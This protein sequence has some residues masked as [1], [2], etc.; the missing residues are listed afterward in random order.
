MRNIMTGNQAA[1]LGAFQSGVAFVTGYPGTPCTEVVS[2]LAKFEGVHWEWA[3][4]E[5]VALEAAIGA[6]LAGVRTLVVM[7]TLG[8]N[9]AADAF[10]QLAGTPMNGGLV[11]VVADDV[12]R[13]VGD[14]YQD[15]R[16][17]SIMSQVPL[18]EPSDSQ[19]A[20]EF[21][22]M[23]F[24]ISET[25]E[26][27]VILRLNSITSKS[28]SVVKL[29]QDVGQRATRRLAHQKS[30]QKTVGNVV[31]FGFPNYDSPMLKEYWHDFKKNWTALQDACNEI[32]I[33]QVE[34]GDREI[35]IIASGVS[36]HYAKEAVPHASF[37]KLGLVFPLPQRLI[38]DFVGSHRTVY[39]IEDGHP[40]IER[41]IRGMG[42][43]VQGENVFPRFPHMLYFTPEIIE[44]KIL[45]IQREKKSSEV[46]FRLPVNCP[47]CPH[48]VVNRILKKNNIKAV[49][50]IGCG[51]LGAFPHVGAMDVVKCMGSSF[52][53]AHGY[54]R[55]RKDG[56]K[57]V[58][59]MGDGEFWHTGM[60]GLINAVYHKGEGV[61]IIE[62][63]FTVAMTGGQRNISS[64]LKQDSIQNRISI[65]AICKTI[66][67]LDVYVVDS[68]DEDRLEG[69]L[70][71][72]MD[73]EGISVIIARHPCLIFASPTNT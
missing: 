17:Y 63:N 27:P 60:N 36:Y 42:L 20:K 39:V 28:K 31:R 14:D 21:M 11:L 66:G 8:L 2:E 51:G 70:L 47:G 43:T 54:N 33:N 23:A 5:K 12:G 73:K 34:M 15:C 25:Y 46:P 65:E 26:V 40:I 3:V 1:A 53:I 45:G 62:D 30:L 32:S 35:G 22:E 61:F 64:P 24:L 69:I 56:K 48:T 49:G 67:I 18:L 59:V 9:V 10:T 38:R 4:N 68:Y 29:E 55:F 16:H 44:E 57:M 72:E 37:L 50:G 58:A 71:R 6:S 7:K 19:E 52:G 41:E 13:I